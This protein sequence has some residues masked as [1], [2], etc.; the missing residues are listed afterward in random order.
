MIYVHIF[1]SGRNMTHAKRK[2]DRKRHRERG[3]VVR[4]EKITIRVF[5]TKRLA[6]TRTENARLRVARVLFAAASLCLSLVLL[7]L[8]ECVCV[9]V[10]LQLSGWFP[11]C[12]RRRE[13]L[14]N[15]NAAAARTQNINTEQKQSTEHAC[16]P[17]L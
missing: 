16:L 11:H 14:F 3:G 10:V 5:K 2:R 6:P 7:V 15:G 12:C 4:E 8:N 9:C 13:R 1:F 17:M